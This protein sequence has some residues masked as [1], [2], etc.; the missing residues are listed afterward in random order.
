MP[1]YKSMY[2][3]LAGRVADAIELLIQAQQEGEDAAMQEDGPDAIVL[4]KEPV[5]RKDD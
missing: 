3:R 4:P 5:H 2:F 1:D